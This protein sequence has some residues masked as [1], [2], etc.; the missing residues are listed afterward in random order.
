MAEGPAAGLPPGTDPEALHG[1]LT[2]R[3]A[4]QAELAERRAELARAADGHGEADLRADLAALTGDDIEG[5]L[6][7]LAAEA[8]DLDQRGQRAFADRDRHE[9]R[10]VELEGGI[11]AELALAQR[12]AAEAELQANARHWAVLKLASLMLGTAIGRHRAGQQDPLLTRSGTLFGALTGGAFAGLAQAQRRLDGALGGGGPVVVGLILGYLNRTGPINWQMPFHTRE[13]LS[14][15][16][17]TLFQAGV[18]TSAGASFRD[19]LTDPS[20][21]TIIGVP[22]TVALAGRSRCSSGFPYSSVV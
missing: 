2:A 22:W 17:L 13:T 10:R 9:R 1:R 21:L 5:S 11:G 6:A 19:A 3:R 18:E 14:N 4:C 16:G 12:K 15:L 7:N 8:E 20:S